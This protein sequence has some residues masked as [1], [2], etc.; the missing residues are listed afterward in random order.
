MSALNWLTDEQMTRLEP[1]FRKSQ[2]RSRVENRRVL[3]GIVFVNRNGARWCDVPKDYGP[4]ETLSNQWK[5][6]GEKGVPCASWKSWPPGG[7]GGEPK[8]VMIDATCL[9][10]R[11]AT[12]S[13]RMKKG[14]LDG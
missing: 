7:G 6:W 2:G 8:T 4:H 12:S 13:L 5:Q 1:S 10:A 3:S 11:R 14:V 9:K